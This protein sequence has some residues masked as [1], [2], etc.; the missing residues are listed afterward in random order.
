MDIE[1]K[2]KYL[3][4]QT[5]YTHIRPYRIAQFGRK[6]KNNEQK[7]PHNLVFQ[8]GA[9]AETIRDIRGIEAEGTWSFTLETNGFVYRRYPSP[10]FT[11]PKDFGDPYH[12]QN[13][14]L[15]ECEAIL[16]NEIEGVERVFIFDWKIRK[17]K[18][19]KERRELNQNLLSFARHVHIA[20]YM[21]FIAF[22]VS[23]DVKNF[24]IWRPIN[25][26]VEDQ[27]IAV[28]DGRTVDT[29]KL[30]ETDMISGDYTGTLLYPLYEPGNIRQ[31]HY[32][33]RQGIEDVL[34]FKSFD[35]KK[36]SVE[37]A[38]HTSFTLP[39]TPSD[40]RPRISVEVRA[41]VFTRSM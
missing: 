37:H 29:S 31:W 38:P 34:L 41:L 19:A 8:E 1:T 21:L 28:C 36:G 20:V 25:G 10:L 24:S 35:S 15:P 4:W 23:S 17:R 5:N 3:Q 16:R 33:S 30:V 32:L 22:L 11:N 13:I 39:D 26:P 18:S 2:L 6:R 27:P 40:A 14:F 12:I 7:T 9:V